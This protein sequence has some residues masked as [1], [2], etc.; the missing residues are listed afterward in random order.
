T[1]AARFMQVDDTTMGEGA[2]YQVRFRGRLLM[3]SRQA[4]ALAAESFREL[5]FTPLFR[6]EGETHVVLAVAGAPVPR[7]SRIWVNYVMF[8][9]TV[10]SVLFTGASYGS[11]GTF[12]ANAAG[13]LPFLATGIPFTIAMLGILL[14]HELGHYFAARYHKVA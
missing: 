9:L 12:P 1:A 10:L 13:W 11:D 14:A 2:D 8:G 3:E 7:P 6:K 5:G 4:Y